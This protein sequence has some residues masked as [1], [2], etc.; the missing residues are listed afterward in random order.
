MRRK[1]ISVVFSI[2]CIWDQMKILIDPNLRLLLPQKRTKLST[3][4]GKLHLQLDIP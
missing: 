3:K 1:R 2:K 4:R